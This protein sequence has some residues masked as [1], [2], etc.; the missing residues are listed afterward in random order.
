MLRKSW[1]IG[2]LLISVWALLGTNAHAY[3][4]TIGG[5]G[6]FPKC[7]CVWSEWLGVANYEIKPTEVDVTIDLLEV[8]LH[9]LNPA[10][11]GGGWG[12]PFYPGVQVTGQQAL[13]LPVSKKGKYLSTICFLDDV[14]FAAIPLGSIPAP[15]NPQWTLDTEGHYVVVLKMYVTIRGYSDSNG[16]GIVDNWETAHVAG[17]CT[18]NSARDGYNCVTEENWGYKKSDPNCPYE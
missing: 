9:Y 7:V 8:Q 12:N 15:P 17:T 18:L 13:N 11:Q 14:L 3:P 2:V 10:G 6:A 1:L 4:G 16:D 5:W